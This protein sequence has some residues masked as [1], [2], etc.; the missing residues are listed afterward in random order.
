MNEAEIHY[1]AGAYP[2]PEATWYDID[3]YL[4][5]LIDDLLRALEEGCWLS[6]STHFIP[7]LSLIM[8]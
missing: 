1:D 8:A 2:R 3:V 4:K 6:L 7:C 5:P